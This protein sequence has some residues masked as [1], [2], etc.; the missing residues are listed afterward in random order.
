MGMPDA[1]SNAAT[2][3][4]RWRKPHG[5]DVAALIT[6]AVIGFALWNR[7]V[8]LVLPGLS[9]EATVPLLLALF[10]GAYLLRMLRESAADGRWCLP[11]T[12]VQAAA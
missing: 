11:A 12:L 5:L 3:T 8:S 6:V 9:P 7:R 1:A 4:P 2:A 10:V